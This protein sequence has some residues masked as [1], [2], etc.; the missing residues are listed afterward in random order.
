MNALNHVAGG[1]VFTGVFA[2]LYDV[3]IF[4]KPQYL[5]VVLIASQI[6]DID[7]SKSII[8]KIFTPLS[9]YLFRHYGHRTITHSL[10]FLI[11]TSLIVYY[12][13][14]FFIKIEYIPLVYALALSSHL[15]FDMM[16]VQGIPLLYPFMRNAFVLPANPKARLSSDYKTQSL[17]FLVFCTLFYFCFPLMSNGFWMTYNNNFTSI[18]HLN[19]SNRKYAE[20]MKVNYR[21]IQSDIPYSGSGLVLKSDQKRIII[22]DSLN[23]I[24]KFSDVDIIHNLEVFRSDKK[25]KI[26]KVNLDRVPLDQIKKYSNALIQNIKISSETKF[27]YN[28]TLHN[29]ISADYINHFTV[30]EIPKDSS[31]YRRLSLELHKEKIKLNKKHQDL[32]TLKS[33]IAHAIHVQKSQKYSYYDKEKAF[34][35]VATT[36]R[37]LDRII[38][39]STAYQLINL[40]LMQESLKLSRVPSY[41]LE[42]SVIAF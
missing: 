7:H 23:G 19:S 41:G 16:T 4:E 30:E 14:L 33:K 24:R 27:R 20:L 39:D 35:T 31:D 17:V 18:K 25:I 34:A 29:R 42:V 1:T 38:I 37:E 11:I 10:L 22:L 36:Q 8:G 2:S 13:N 3:N 5:V 12:L 40:E 26:T 15:I 21:I 9:R 6:P 32:E 28:G